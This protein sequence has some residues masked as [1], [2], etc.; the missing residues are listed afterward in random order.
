[1]SSA[2]AGRVPAE[3]RGQALGLQQSAGGLARVVGPAA[4][5]VLFGQVGV[6]VPYLVA[7]VPG[8]AGG[9]ARA[10]RAARGLAARALTS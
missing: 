9:R 6:A 3:R 10:R 7:A 4:A 8:G 5:G 1:M 2:V